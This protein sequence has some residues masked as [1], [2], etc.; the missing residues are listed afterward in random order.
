MLDA[1][2][3]IPLHQASPSIRLRVIRDCWNAR[4]PEP[5]VEEV[6]AQ[7]SV[8]RLAVSLRRDG[9]W[10]S[11]LHRAG[12]STEN[13]VTR[14]AELACPFDRAPFSRALP[15]LLSILQGKPSPFLDLRR[16]AP[17]PEPFWGERLRRVAA[18]LLCQ[19]GCAERKEVAEVVAREIERAHS[20]VLEVRG[21]GSGPKPHDSVYGR[22]SVDD[23][24]GGVP[25]L[26]WLRAVAFSPSLARDRR[27]RDILR[28]LLESHYQRLVER[29]LEWGTVAG[30]RVRTGFGVRALTPPRALRD[31]RM[32][33]V[34]VVAELLAR[35]GEARPA[36]E[37]IR[38]LDM[39]RDVRGRVVLPARAFGRGG[40]YTIRQGWMQ[41][42]AP[43]RARARSIDLTFRKLLLTRLSERSRAHPE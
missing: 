16:P 15:P 9:T 2:V 39:R 37:L 40:G 23:E 20:W 5:L 21:G 34:L 30:R 14:L 1:P 42:S 12:A 7:P 32:G 17:L 13:A 33:E 41:L 11:W 10:A 26:Y 3:P 4:P 38:F 43:W 22:E 8:A 6:L 28:F 36:R 19:V 27:V 25:D 29:D 31:G 24:G 35:A 18:G